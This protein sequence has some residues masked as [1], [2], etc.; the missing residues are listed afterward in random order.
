MTSIYS[1]RTVQTKP[2]LPP[3]VKTEAKIEGT[4]A[5]RWAKYQ[6][7]A[8]AENDKVKGRNYTSKVEQGQMKRRGPCRGVTNSSRVLDFM[9]GKGEV[10][11]REIQEEL[12]DLT[13]KQVS[14]A[15][16]NLRKREAVDLT[17]YER[18][19]QDNVA[20]WKVVEDAA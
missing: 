15:L 1:Y 8:M 14:S 2:V 5:A 9:Q 13:R 3:K 17:R 11:A 20:F 7:M 12:S 4:P 6:A 16:K 10:T 19:Q 18:T